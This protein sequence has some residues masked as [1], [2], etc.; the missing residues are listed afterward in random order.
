MALKKPVHDFESE[1]HIQNNQNSSIIKQLFPQKN[2]T[3]FPKTALINAF[4]STQPKK[5]SWLLACSMADASK[6]RRLETTASS[7]LV[8]YESSTLQAN[9]KEATEPATVGGWHI[10]H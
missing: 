7:Q 4:V 8:A 2:P 3:L 6:R 1:K 9:R 5:H 10:C